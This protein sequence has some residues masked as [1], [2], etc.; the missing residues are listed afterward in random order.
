MKDN[1][2][3]LTAREKQ[4]RAHGGFVT[5]DLS[6]KLAVLS[7]WSKKVKK[8][9]RPTPSRAPVLVQVGRVYRHYKGARYLVLALGQDSNNDRNQEL[10]VYYCSVDPGPRAGKWRNRFA[11]EWCE[12][13]R[14]PSN[15]MRPRFA[16]EKNR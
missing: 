1:R 13:V 5:D 6:R 15:A 9:A 8:Q 4:V 11:S 10:T 7:S 16:L 2:R 14:W 3:G 12:L